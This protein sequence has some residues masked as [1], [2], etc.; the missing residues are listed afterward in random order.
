MA[1]IGERV[2]LAGELGLEELVVD[3]IV[4]CLGYMSSK[5]DGSLDLLLISSG[6]M[7]N[8]RDRSRPFVIWLSKCQSIPDRSAG[9]RLKAQGR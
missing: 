4:E 8:L 6:R 7:A 2:R 3:G 9:L 1:I 5:F